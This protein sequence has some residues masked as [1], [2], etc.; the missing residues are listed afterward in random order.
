VQERTHAQGATKISPREAV[1]NDGSANPVRATH[2]HQRPARLSLS[3]R[4]DPV[5]DEEHPV[6]RLKK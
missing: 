1:H 4:R 3:A 5:I 2:V 6:T